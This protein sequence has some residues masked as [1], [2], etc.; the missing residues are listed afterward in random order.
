MRYKGKKFFED[1]WYEYY[2]DKENYLCS[3]CANSGVIDTTGI[4]SPSGTKTGRKNWCI[5][6]NGQAMRIGTKTKSPKEYLDK[7]G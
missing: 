2:L 1:F 5:C 4:Q 6:P 3:L 7:A